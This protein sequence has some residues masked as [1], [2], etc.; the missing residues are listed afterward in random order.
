MRGFIALR[1]I[2]G[3]V[4]LT[5]CAAEAPRIPH[6]KPVAPLTLQVELIERGQ[7]RFEVRAIAVPTANV[8]GLLL[9]LHLPA[10]AVLEEGEEAYRFGATAVGTSR[11]Q[12]WH[13]KL[14]VPGA[15]VIAEARVV[16]GNHER[17]RAHVVRL[18]EP[19]A[20]EKPA[21]TTE[22]VLPNG[23]RVQEVR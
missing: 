9:R 17:N 4:L 3:A 7:Q 23:V 15:D 19:K 22:I 16:D 6:G 18:G 2:C 11:S 13:I 10:G 21:P 8:A 5:S 12:L 1:L 14:S 20:A